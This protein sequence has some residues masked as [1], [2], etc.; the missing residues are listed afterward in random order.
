M[1]ISVARYKLQL[2]DNLLKLKL[3][4]FY[5]NKKIHSWI[6]T[7]AHTSP[8]FYVPLF[9]PFCHLMFKCMHPKSITLVL[10]FLQFWFSY[11]QD[12]NALLPR[13]TLNTDFT[14]KVLYTKVSNSVTIFQKEMGHFKPKTAYFIL[15]I[16]VSHGCYLMWIIFGPN[17]PTSSS[18]RLM[19][20]QCYFT[21]CNKEY[22]TCNHHTPV[23]TGYSIVQWYSTTRSAIQQQISVINQ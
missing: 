21:S 1:H 4:T 3:G 15:F 23:K 10:Y 14:V 7:N 5:Q 11:I 12:S 22:K 17:V 9:K 8:Q 19:S 13:R 6:T 2:H 16:S 18:W 20:F